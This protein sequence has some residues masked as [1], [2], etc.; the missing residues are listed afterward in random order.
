[1]YVRIVQIE[2]SKVIKGNYNT[3]IY[4]INHLHLKQKK[5][6]RNNITVEVSNNVT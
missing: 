2:V 6:Q 4:L 1:M 5:L 3:E